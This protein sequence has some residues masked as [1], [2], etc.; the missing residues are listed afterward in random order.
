MT[1][2]KFP[3]GNI[4]KLVIQCFKI[5]QVIL[6]PKVFHLILTALL[7]SSSYAGSLETTWDITPTHSILFMNGGKVFDS[8][9]SIKQ[10]PLNLSQDQVIDFSMLV[11][12]YYLLKNDKDSYFNLISL[13]KNNSSDYTMLVELLEYFWRSDKGDSSEAELKFEEY[14]KKETNT[15]L[16]LLGN[17]LYQFNK[18]KGPSRIDFNELKSISCSRNKIYYS[19]CRLTKLRT[20]IEIAGYDGIS[21]QKEYHF[22]DR[23]LAPFMEDYDLSYISFLDKIIPDLAPKLAFLGFA[24]EAVHFQ[25][26]IL[27]TEKLSNKFDIITH[28]RLAFYQLLVGDLDAAED[29]LYNSLKNL[30]TLSIIRNGVLLKLGTI[31][32]LRKDYEQSLLYFTGLNMKYWGKTLRHPLIDET[33]SPNGARELVALVISKA[34]NPGLAVEAL[35]KLSTNKSDEDDLFLRLR[36]AQIMF[37]TRPAFTE[38]ITDDIIYTAQSKGW[39]RLEYA[40]TILNGYACITNKK[41]RKAVVQF[42]K[43]AGILGGSDPFVSEWTRLAGMLTARVQGKERGNH[44]SLYSKLILQA[45]NGEV[46]ADELS[47]KMY[48]DSRYNIEE[49]YKQSINYFISTRDYDSLLGA[50][51]YEQSKK[52]G[53]NYQRSLLQIPGV[54]RRIR[55]FRGFRSSLDNIYYK[56]YP[57]KVRE[58]MHQKMTQ[59]NEEFNINFIKKINDPFIVIFNSGEYINVLGYQPDKSRWTYL[60]FNSNEYNTTQY[61][62]RILNTFIFIDKSSVYQIY[63]N[64]SG[65]DLFQV[66]KKNGYASNARLFY[67]FQ[68]SPKKEAKDLEVVAPE[69]GNDKKVNGFFYYPIDYYEGNK[70]FE[71]TNRL[72]VWKFPEAINKGNVGKFDTYSWKCD[73]KN[74]LYFHKMERRLDSKGTPHSILMTNPILLDSST[75]NLSGDFLYWSD[76]WMKRGTSYIYFMDKIENDSVTSECLQTFSKLYPEN[77]DLTHVQDYLSTNSRD[78]VIL[79]REPR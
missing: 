17:S 49:F 30:R 78:S 43:S 58:E 75:T 23:S 61:Y 28:E 76:F 35:N 53:I 46:F 52:Q 48:L 15:Y 11:G 69:C 7:C 25:K 70:Q 68:S 8:R 34:K 63:L 29:T 27:Q 1:L 65:I 2:E 51:Y 37:S 57:S 39:K 59:E 79:M 77:S 22:M 9:E 20:G 4:L 14:L 73:S 44:G 56:G 3:A 12:E 36:I 6:K 5:I 41:H 64:K 72:Q 33:I 18:K 47:I 40:A 67:N 26:M 66:L 62:T 21:A 42:T 55:E 71:S 10:L 16:Y 54:S 50:L 13:I 31:A 19:L 60:I 24:G 74:V 38:K 32:Y 45:N